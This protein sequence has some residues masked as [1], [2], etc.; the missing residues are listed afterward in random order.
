MTNSTT[1]PIDNYN[2]NVISALLSIPVGIRREFVEILNAL[3]G[4][5]HAEGFKPSVTVSQIDAMGALD[6]VSAIA[7]A[8]MNL[9]Y[10]MLANPATPRILAGVIFDKIE[11]IK[12]VQA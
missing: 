12:G 4:V 7:D 6:D 11:V 8:L 9:N 1:K 2:Q 3:C 10:E 5:E